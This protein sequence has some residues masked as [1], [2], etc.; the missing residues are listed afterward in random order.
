MIYLAGDN[1]LSPEMIRSLQG[2]KDAANSKQVNILVGLDSI[3]LG[4]KFIKLNGDTSVATGFPSSSVK[5]DELPLETNELNSSESVKELLRIATTDYPADN[6]MLIVF[7]HGP[8]IRGAFLQDS[9]PVSAVTLTEF[10]A[11]L[12]GY[13]GPDKG[14]KLGVLG[15]HN[16]IISGVELVYQLRDTVEYILGSQGLVLRVGWPY[17]R[18]LN[19]ITSPLENGATELAT[20]L[21]VAGRMLRVCA[22]HNY[23]YYEYMDRSFEQALC[24]APKSLEIV[25]A[26]RG[27]AEKPGLATLLLQN[28]NLLKETGGEAQELG[29]LVREAINLARLEAQSFWQ[30][31]FV[32]LADF[33]SLLAD[34]C[35]FFISLAGNKGNFGDELDKIA[36]ACDTVKQAIEN[37]VMGDYY[38]GPERQYATGLSIYFPWAVP[39]EMITVKGPEG[40]LRR[41]AFA[42]YCSYIFAQDAQWGDFLVAFLASTLRAARQ[43]DGSTKLFPD[44]TQF[45][46]S[47]NT[48]GKSNQEVGKSNQEVG[49]SNQEVDKSNQEV[50]KSNQEVGKSN[51]EVGKSN[52]EVGKSNQE[53]GDESCSCMTNNFPNQWQPGIVLQQLLNESDQSFFNRY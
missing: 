49:K 40:P 39:N 26:L 16:C 18:L 1:D 36:D 23:D 33:C 24:S 45:T 41:Q 31:Q 6:Y 38:I 29:R 21:Q 51:Q 30:S 52:Q 12:A 50:D 37:T 11:I 22:K 5:H 7:G 47:V 35:R 4:T 28:L 46:E 25:A 42:D 32:D 2:M 34:K 3:S 19:A 27:N 8:I 14:R 53:V 48:V 15:L 9:H 43:S 20:P 13:F 17:Q 44:A 10:S